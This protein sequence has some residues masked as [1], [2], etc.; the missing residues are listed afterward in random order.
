LFPAAE[1]IDT[2]EE[3]LGFQPKR[4]EYLLAASKKAVDNVAAFTKKL[5]YLRNHNLLAAE[6]SVFIMDYQYPHGQAER[7]NL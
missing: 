1:R 2:A 7:A 3:S 4:V 5:N 6:R